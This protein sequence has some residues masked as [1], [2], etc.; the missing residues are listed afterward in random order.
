MAQVD[1]LKVFRLKAF[2]GT[3]CVTTQHFED[4]SWSMVIM[5]ADRLKTEGFSL[6]PEPL[7]T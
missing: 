2:R 7:N 1:R 3:A 5:Q 4:V 6:Q